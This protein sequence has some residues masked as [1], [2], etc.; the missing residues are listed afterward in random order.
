MKEKLKISV[1]TVCYNMEGTIEETILSVL[2]QNYPNLEYIIIDGNSTD[3]TMLIVNKYKD[4][5]STIVSE[6]DNGMY[7]AIHKGFSMATG[8]ILAW[9]NADDSY[10]P[11]TFKYVNEVFTTYPDVDW[12]GG[13]PAFMDEGR[14]LTDI[15]S[16][17][18]AKD[19]KDIV[20]GRFQS[21]IFGCLQQEG[22]FWR[23]SLYETSGGLNVNYRY[24]GDF[25]L[26]IKFAKK[27][28]LV[29]VQIPLAAFMRRHDSLSIGSNDKYEA[30]IM[31]I[32]AGLK[33]YPT[34]L[35]KLF[36]KNKKCTHL[37]RLLTYRKSPNLLYSLSEKRFIYKE[38][39]RSVSY[40]TLKG[41]ML[42]QHG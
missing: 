4:K 23:K 21:K 11:W 8:D 38:T 13:L 1:V 20:N 14:I 7:D 29:S 28:K 39:R 42:Y 2:N 19:Q 41:L 31:Q 15:F 6:P 40:H 10:M 32:T 3:D 5:I 33:V 34:F 26:W 36:M 18:G 27:A 16:Y 12:I 24:A 25:D 9:I 17:P 30:E 22:M 37:A 35:Y